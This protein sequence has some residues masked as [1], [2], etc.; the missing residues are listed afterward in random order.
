MNVLRYGTD[1]SV[2]LEFAQGVLLADCGHPAGEPLDDVERAVAAALNEPLA[3][4][5]LSR[6]TTPSDRVVLALDHGI[7]QAAQVTAAVVQ[8]LLDAQVHP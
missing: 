4:P 1:S 8:S 6:C 2:N 3:Y 5:A 7:P